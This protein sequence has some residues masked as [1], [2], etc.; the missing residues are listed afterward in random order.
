MAM[1]HSVGNASEKPVGVSPWYEASPTSLRPTPT[2][3]Q[4]YGHCHPVGLVRFAVPG[5]SRVSRP[6]LFTTAPPGLE[7]NPVSLL[8]TLIVGALHWGL[9]PA[10]KRNG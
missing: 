5:L 3:G 1:S 10:V 7:D 9:D 2:E 6:W 4:S 8:E